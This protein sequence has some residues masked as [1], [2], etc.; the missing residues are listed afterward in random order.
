MVN[1]IIDFS[2]LIK[3]IILLSTYYQDKMFIIANYKSV[4]FQRLQVAIYIYFTKHHQTK[5][6]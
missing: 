1:N 5:G 4:C 2:P 3:N 6:T